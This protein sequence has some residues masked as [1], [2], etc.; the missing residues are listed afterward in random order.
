MAAEIN[1]QF[2]WFDPDSPHWW[3]KN[4]LLAPSADIASK[5]ILFCFARI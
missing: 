4:L 3:R 1:L 5:L 2:A